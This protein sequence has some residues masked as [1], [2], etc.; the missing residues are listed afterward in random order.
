MQNFKRKEKFP[1]FDVVHTVLSAHVLFS[2]HVI[3]PWMCEGTVETFC[4][5]TTVF[6]FCTAEYFWFNIFGYTVL[7]WLAL[8]VGRTL[9]QRRF[10]ICCDKALRGLIIARGRSCA[11]Y[12]GGNSV[13][14][15]FM[16]SKCLAVFH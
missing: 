4:K 8:A 3:L 5:S 11:L 16:S 9:I 15:D 14:I 2:V 1:S 7:P 12:Y 13:C 6:I 10:V